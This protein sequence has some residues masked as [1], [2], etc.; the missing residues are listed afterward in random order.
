M[1]SL[2]HQK[3]L[4]VGQCAQKILKTGNRNQEPILNWPNSL[5]DLFAD[6]K[7]LGLKLNLLLYFS[8]IRVINTQVVSDF[9]EIFPWYHHYHQY[10]GTRINAYVY[11]CTC[12]VM[13]I[14]YLYMDNYIFYLSNNWQFSLPL[15]NFTLL[16]TRQEKDCNAILATTACDTKIL[17]QNHKTI[18]KEKCMNHFIYIY[19]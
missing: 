3:I 1:L 17:V 19:I 18:T 9:N 12:C 8:K 15:E 7:E 14:Y 4:D 5:K 6:K 16:K 2:L 10:K 13:H 11:I